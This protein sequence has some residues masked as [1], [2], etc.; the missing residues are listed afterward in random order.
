ME[1]LRVFTQ[2][3]SATPHD[4]MVQIGD[5]PLW[6]YPTEEVHISVT[7][8][9]DKAEGERLKRAYQKIYKTVKIGGPAYND[10]GGEFMPG[11]YVKKGITITSRGCPRSCQFC[12]VP[13]REGTIRLLPIQAG[14]DIFDNNILACPR[15]HIEAV[16]QMLSEQRKA[17]RFSGGIDARLV[18]EW[19]VKQLAELRLD[20]LFTAYDRPSQWEAVKKA[21]PMM[22]GAGFDRRKIGCYVLVGQMG[23]TLEDAEQR[24]EAIW[25]LGGMPFAMYSQDSKGTGKIAGEWRP[26]IRKWTR[27]AA[28]FSSHKEHD[29]GPPEK[30]I[31]CKYCGATLKRDAVGRFCPTQNCQWH[32]GFDEEEALK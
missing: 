1:V 26:L 32:H 31:Y 19:W 20:I 3:T 10:A 25:E 22:R 2:G 29:V 7:F 23:D 18:E 21:I 16:M 28:M 14:H 5:P 9:W 24:L 8:T 4:D 30:R 12:F 17:A 11:M 15:E 13:K 6:K 27:P